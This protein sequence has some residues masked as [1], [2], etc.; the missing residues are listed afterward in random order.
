MVF[1][2][3]EKK[4]SEIQISR[5]NRLLD[6]IRSTQ[7]LYIEKNRSEKIFEGLLD[8]LVEIT[9]SEF[10]FLDEVIKDENGR[11]FKR[12]LAMSGVFFEKAPESFKKIKT[13]TDLVFEDLDNISGRP[14]VTGQIM[15]ENAMKRKTKS[16]KFPKDHPAMQNFMGIPIV[17]SGEIIGVAGIANREGGYDRKVAVFIGPLV[18]ACAGIIHGFKK[19]NAQKQSVDALNNER[20]Q[21]LSIFNSMDEFIYVADPDTYELLFMNQVAIRVWGDHI[22]QKCHQVLQKR[23]EPCPFC[24][25][26]MIFGANLGKT[27]IWEIENEISKTWYRCIDR[28]IQ[29]NNEKMMRF[30]MAID[31]DDSKR[32]REILEKSEQKF[33]TM[34]DFTSDWVYWISPN[35]NF[36]YMSPSSQAVCGYKPEDFY[37]KPGLIKEIV[38]AQDKDLFTKHVDDFCKGPKE[39]S[40]FSGIEFRI[41]DKEGRIRWISHLCRPVYSKD[42]EFLGRR[43]SNR[44]ITLKKTNDSR[45]EESE[46]RF[47]FLAENAR[48]TIYKVNLK[49]KVFAEFISPS[50]YEMLGYHAEE[51]YQDRSLIKKVICQE[52]YPVFRKVITGRIDYKSPLLSRFIH[53]DGHIVWA[54]Q[55][56]TPAYKGTRLVGLI[57]ILR[58]VTEKVFFEE[59]L[60]YIS[61]HDSLTG[62]Y[63]RAYF[64]V[65]LKRLDTERQL[66]ISLIMADLNGLKL[67]NDAFGHKNG[68]K[69][70]IEASRMLKKCCREEDVVS[71][72][73]G[74]EFL[75]LLPKTSN[76][77]ALEIIE[78]INKRCKR[79]K[80]LKMPLSMS[81][82]AS[83]K[84]DAK[85][86]LEHLIKEAEDNMY[87]HKL[88]ESRS[89]QNAIIRSLTS[90]LYEKS[91]ETKNHSDRV[92]D[93]SLRLAKKVGLDPNKMDE[94]ILH[95]RL[96]DIGKVAIK[97]ELMNKEKLNMQE[98]NSI[99]KH[100]EIGYRI[101]R[102]SPAIAPIADYILCHHEWWNGYGYPRGLKGEKIPMISRIVSIIDAYDAMISGRPYASPKCIKDALAELKKYAGLQFDPSLVQKFSEIIQEA[103]LSS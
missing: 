36:V 98:F 88:L 8:T 16:S 57:G 20:D 69:L 73:G 39:K 45:L 18:M 66:P 41:L 40:A 60:K 26:P 102:S 43:V 67:I 59:K 34:V 17:F 54:E 80:K 93:L 51:F 25:N 10:G 78:K 71:R 64:D 92:A 84:Y 75:V 90:A 55:K 50:V 32:S 82:G 83:T 27:Y 12:N 3:T 9:D 30:E 77:R 58:D 38:Y 37:N 52:E 42:Q 100:S 56:V 48:D 46:R 68:D 22:G 65:E 89:T 13:N 6:S 23:G 87:K 85:K 2:I 72:W 35:E 103:E 19:E 1:N 33:K 95:A 63:N 62:L 53:Q 5:Q 47:R 24:S 4:H 81:L 97:E 96:H 31:I 61:F 11:S 74:D 44:D 14:A 91:M 70:L 79:F 15:I 7:S 86:N 99:K 94:L 21:L 76:V 49:P 101:A 28:A 29:W